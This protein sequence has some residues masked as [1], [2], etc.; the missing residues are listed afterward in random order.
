MKKRLPIG[1]FNI[2]NL[3]NDGFLYVDKTQFVYKLLTSSKYYFLS[4]LHR[5]GKSLFVSTL[6]QVFK[7]NKDLFKGLWI[8][9][10]GYDW[11]FYPV[12][13]IDFNQI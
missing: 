12:V 3:I 9:E 13:K 1:E 11:G 7:G 6:E 2:A 10:S 8:Y 5:F 4:C